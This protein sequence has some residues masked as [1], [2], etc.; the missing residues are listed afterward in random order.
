MIC[1][2]QP[3]HLCTDW[4]AVERYWGPQRAMGTYAFRALHEAGAVL[5]FGSDAPVEPVDPRLA[6]HAALTRTDLS[7]APDGGWYPAERLDRRTALLAYTAGP[8]LAAGAGG[9]EGVLRPGAWADL[10]AWHGDPLDPEVGPLELEC[11]AAMVAGDV[12]WRR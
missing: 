3:A 10:A 11:V 6:L 2:V 5:A 12:A 8:A 9:T 4:R 7:G 1:S